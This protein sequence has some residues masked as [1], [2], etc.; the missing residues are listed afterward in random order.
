MK[1]QLIRTLLAAVVFS[2]L[3]LSCSK[4]KPAEYF[5]KFKV[6]GEEV[7][8]KKAH[9][10]VQPA[11]DPDKIYIIIAGRSTDMKEV[12]IVDVEVPKEPGPATF[13]SETDML[14][15]GYGINGTPGTPPIP[16]RY[17]T[18]WPISGEPDPH[19]TLTITAISETEIRGHFTGTY[20][21]TEDGTNTIA[22]PEGS[23]VA[24][25]Q[26]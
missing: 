26:E 19:F 7:E 21:A 24:K 11:S 6:D 12:F 5:I 25:L 14:E 15:F 22:V 8:F 1:N 17:Y 9:F 4:E 23:F 3:F 2:S 18:M 13:D 10:I 20:L 16:A